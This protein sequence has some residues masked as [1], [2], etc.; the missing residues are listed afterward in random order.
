MRAAELLALASAHGINLA[1]VHLN[2]AAGP[3]KPWHDGIDL[4]PNGRRC[5]SRRRRPEPDPAAFDEDLPWCAVRYSL[6]GDISVHWPLWN[7]LVFQAVRLG[8]REHWPPQVSARRLNGTEP[9]PRFY[10]LELCQLVLDEESMKPAFAAAPQLRAICLGIADR[11][12]AHAVEPHYLKLQAVY[13]HWLE[14]GRERIRAW[15]CEA[16][17]IDSLD[18]KGLRPKPTGIPTAV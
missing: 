6:A 4:V 17:A 9:P 13:G 18:F 1:H 3:R 8:R 2:G 10:L 5:D 14:L 15:I 7:G 16:A 12:W 11:A